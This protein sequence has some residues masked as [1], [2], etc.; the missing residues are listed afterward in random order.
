MP[1]R[2]RTARSSKRNASTDEKKATTA[3]A[4]TTPARARPNDLSATKGKGKPKVADSTQDAAPTDVG[5]DN[6]SKLNGGV[7]V[8]NADAKP[9]AGRTLYDH[10]ISSGPG[11]KTISCIRNAEPGCTPAPL[12]FTHGAG[13]GLSAPAVVNFAQGVVDAGSNIVCFKGNMNLKSRTRMFGS[14][15]EYEKQ[16]QK[17]DRAEEKLAFGGRSMGARAAAL[18]AQEADDVKILVLVSYPLVGPNGDVRDQIL[19]DIG[20]DVDVLFI[21][22]DGDNMCDLRRLEEVREKMNAKSWMVLVEGADHGMHLRGGGGKKRTDM[23]GKGTGRVA[24]RWIV[25]RD[26]QKTEMIVKW[27]SSREA[28]VGSESWGSGEQVG[29]PG[30]KEEDDGKT[31]QAKKGVGKRPR[32]KVSADESKEIK[33]ARKRLRGRKKAS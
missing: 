14:V 1:P 16:K 15:L 21:S 28:V 7:P 27:D 32:E 23:M 31:G 22:G 20:T 13:G 25:N 11:S 19:L 6:D 17:Q 33:P 29:E 10:D 24:A 18:A 5:D 4:S 9:P 30:E 26:K 3:P 12:I 2:K 8:T